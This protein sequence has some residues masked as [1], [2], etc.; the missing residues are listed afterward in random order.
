MVLV[1][2]CRSDVSP[3]NNSEGYEANIAVH[4]TSIRADLSNSME[5]IVQI[6]KDSVKQIC[7]VLKQNKR[8]QIPDSLCS[9]PPHPPEIDDPYIKSNMV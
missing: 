8:W 9:P 1:Y 7:H 6:V 4:T 2:D 3:V 5:M